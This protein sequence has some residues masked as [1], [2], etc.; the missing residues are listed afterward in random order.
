MNTYDVVLH[1]DIWGNEEEGWQVNDSLAMGQVALSENATDVEVLQVL[2]ELTGST[3]FVEVSLLE[4][5]GS[6]ID[7]NDA[8]DGLPLFTL[9]LL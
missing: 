7:V 2:S 1:T 8:R 4:D 3:G 9:Y 6:S 5:R